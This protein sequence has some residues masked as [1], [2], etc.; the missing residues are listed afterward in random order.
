MPGERIHVIGVGGAAGSGASI[1]ATGA[2]AVVT[3]CDA[4]GPSPYDRA[5]ADAGIAIAW[6]HDPSHVTGSAGPLVD[7]VAV[8]KALTSVSPDHPELAAARGAGIPLE[9]VQQVIADAAATLGRRLVGV[10]GTHGKSTTTGWVLHQLVEAGRDPSAFVGALLPTHLSGTRSAA[11]ARLGSGPEVVVEADEYA[12]N[13]DPYE[14]AIGAV[15][16]AEWDHPDVFSDETAVVDSIASWVERFDRA[17]DPPVLVANAGDHG[18]RRLLERLADWRGRLT[19]VELVG[20]SVGERQDQRLVTALGPARRI[21]GRIIASDTGGEDLLVDGIEEERATPARINLV[22]S[23]MAV[24]GLVALAVALE[25][26]VG[27]AQAIRSLATFAGVG[28]RLE[29][30]G[31]ISGIVVLDD[32]GHHPTAIRATFEAVRQRYPGRPIWAVYEP[33]TF[34]RTAAMLD[35]FADVLA[36]A[37]RVA[38]VD[39]WAVRDLD[40]TSVS[41]EDLARATRARGTPALASGSPEASAERLAELVEPGDV[42]V[43]MG[44][45]RSYVVAERLAEL[46]AQADP[47]ATSAASAASS[48]DTGTA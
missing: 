5:V 24:D 21:V 19:T 20:G 11:T 6:E 28:R 18:V 44:G 13:F 9:S 3:A 17:G 38:I 35:A 1:L 43:V 10:T 31:D 16:T 37:D 39:I 12:G 15:V 22:G 36:T 32:Y 8:T 34:H 47:A 48:S 33:L 29:L 23:H 25:I 46:L 2:G 45:G 41:A 7:R 4:A 40:T 14:P 30:K 27:S 26:G 42:V